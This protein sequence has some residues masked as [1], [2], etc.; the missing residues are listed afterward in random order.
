MSCSPPSAPAASGSTSPLSPKPTSGA[1]V[2]GGA[3]ALQAALSGALAALEAAQT[4]EARAL[5]T[6]LGEAGYPDRLAR[7]LRRDLEQRHQ[8]TARRARTD[9]LAE[10]VTALEWRYR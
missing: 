10:V 1:P 4:A 3:E 9:V 8:R 7:R 6:E 5:E 2:A